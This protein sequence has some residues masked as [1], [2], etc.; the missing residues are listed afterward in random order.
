M[1]TFH[2]DL[3]VKYEFLANEYRNKLAQFDED[4]STMQLQI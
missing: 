1:S 2:N 4:I 3:T